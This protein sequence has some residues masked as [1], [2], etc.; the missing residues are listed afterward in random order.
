MKASRMRSIDAMA[1]PMPAQEYARQGIIIVETF[2]RKPRTCIQS[3]KE[4]QE[5][6]R[7]EDVLERLEKVVEAMESGEIPLSDLVAKF[8]EGSKLLKICRQHLRTADLRIE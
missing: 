2:N 1:P 7:F 6:P 4:T 3:E 8:E 5:E